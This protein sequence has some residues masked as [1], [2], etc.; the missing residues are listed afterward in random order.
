[1][2]VIHIVLGKANPNRMNGV[3]KVVF[4]LATHQCSSGINVSVWG[5]TAR[6]EKNYGERLFNTRLYKKQLNPFKADEKL[7]R[8]ILSKRETAVFHIHGGWVPVFYTLAQFMGRHGIIFVFTPHGAYN[9]IA[10]RRSALMKRIYFRLFEWHILH[11]THC[12]HCI[13]Q[14]EISGLAGIH[15]N[16]K[17]ALLPYGFEFNAGNEINKQPAEPFVFGFVGRLDI[18]T[19]GLDLLLQAF[20]EFCKSKPA[21]RL[22]I[23]GD[24]P[25]RNK[26]E[27]MS[28]RKNLSRHI[29]FWGS[30]FG[31]EKD[32]L[33]KQM[34][35]FVHP[36]RNEGLPSSVLE[37]CCFG[38]PCIVS[39]ATN[40][41]H[42]VEM[43]NA[44]ITIGNNDP[45]QLLRGME[46]L[47]RMTGTPIYNLLQNNARE[48]VKTEFDW[49]ALIP[50]FNKLYAA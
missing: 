25:G 50:E 41:G 44:G 30:R 21:A 15:H 9:T 5:I 3:N 13:G 35:A 16:N 12:I 46:L 18:Y 32:D 47:Y 45:Q 4:Q 48:M 24:G 42:Y 28:R 2:E 38:V 37:A 22:W 19:K 10:M 29:V 1:M 7:L 11:H 14:S 31:D 40:V 36:S 20:A 39:K 8:D 49:N 17:A 26:F 27:Q 6:P 43:H 33:I 34:H 23:I